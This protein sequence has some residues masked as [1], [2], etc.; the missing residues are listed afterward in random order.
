M[1]LSRERDYYAL[2]LQLPVL[3]ELGWGRSR[4]GE[5]D[6]DGPENSW[7][8]CLVPLVIPYRHQGLV[9]EYLP[10]TLLELVCM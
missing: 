2:G 4:K 9:G 6:F 10:S 5:R 1:L 3:G 7:H 8:I